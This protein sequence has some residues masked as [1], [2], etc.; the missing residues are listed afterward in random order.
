MEPRRLLFTPGDGG[1]IGERGRAGARWEVR[2]SLSETKIVSEEPKKEIDSKDARHL[3]D[4]VC[5]FVYL[6]KEKQVD[7]DE[8]EAEKEE[9]GGGE[10]EE[11][12][13]KNKALLS[14]FCV[15]RNVF[16]SSR[17]AGKNRRLAR[18][19][20]FSPNDDESQRRPVRRRRGSM[21]SSEQLSQSDSDGRQ[22]Q[23]HFIALINSKE[24]K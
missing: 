11:K 6:T 15:F 22:Q 8:E 17:S 2:I 16:S 18:L 14:C 21:D 23:W 12:R 10:R 24:N 3:T 1:R 5:R 7:D 4:P 13:Q 19:H 20:T 9:G